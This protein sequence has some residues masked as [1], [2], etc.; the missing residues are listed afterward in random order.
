MREQEAV[1]GHDELI[2]LVDD[3]Q[4]IIKTGKDVLESLGYAVM[5]ATDGRQAVEIFKAHSQEIDLVIMDVVM[6]VMGGA[7]AAQNMR[8][9]NPDA[10]VIFST[11]YDKTLQTDME[12]EVVLSKPF[13]IV[14]MSHLIRQLLT[15]GS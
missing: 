7:K 2:L 3:Q 8:R 11:G 9:I 15:S 13:S 6:P 12:N 14:E 10:K 4:Q 5:T 1:R